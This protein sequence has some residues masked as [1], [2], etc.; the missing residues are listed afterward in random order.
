[1]KPIFLIGLLLSVITVLQANTQTGKG[2][3]TGRIVNQQNMP[4]P[5]ATVVLYQLPDTT[6]AQTH[7][8]S[9]TGTFVF[10]EIPIGKYVLKVTHVG[11]MDYEDKYL[12]LTNAHSSIALPVI[13]LQAGTQQSLKDVVVTATKPLIE[14]RIDRTIVNVDAMI[15]ASGYNALEALSKSPGVMV[16]LNDNISLNGKN[17]VLVLIDDRPTY[18][19]GADLAAYLRSLPAGMLDKFELISNPP[20]R[21]DAAGGV[22][23]NILLKKYHTNGLNGGLSAGY[24][25]G[26]YGKTN[27]ALNINY[28]TPQFNLFG[29][30][31]YG[32]DQD[33][34]AATFSR[35]FYNA[36]DALSSSTLQNSHYHSHSNGWNGRVG[37]DYF[38]SSKTTIGVMLTGSTRPKNDALGYQNHQYYPDMLPDSS[39]IG[40]TNGNYTAQN[41]GINLNM[42]HKFNSKGAQLTADLDALYLKSAGDQFSS[43]YVYLGDG[44]DAGTQQRRFLSPSVVHIYSAK[45]DFNQPLAGNAEVEAGV[46]SSFVSNNNQLNW[47]NVDNGDFIPDYQNSNHFRYNENIN[48]LYANIKKNWSRWG[49]QFGLRIENTNA[50][51]RQFSNPVIADSSFAKHY[52]NL[53]PAAYL[54]Y[55][56]D[57]SGH[58]TLT[59]SY[60][61]KMRRPG[62]QQ[63]NPFLFYLDQYSFTAGNTNLAPTYGHYAELRFAYKQYVSITAGYGWGNNQAQSLTQAFGNVFITRPYN[64]I[65]SET[66]S[67]V[68]FFS[69]EPTKWWTLHINAVLLYI[70]NKGHAGDVDINQKTNVHEIETSNEFKLG[71]GWSGELDGF[72]P[73]KQSFAQQANGSIYNISGGVRKKI[74]N[75]NGT[76]TFTINDV[77]HTLY[78]IQGQTIGIKQVAADMTKE[79]DTRRI[80]IAFSYRFGKQANARK[81]NHNTGGAEDEKGRAN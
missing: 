57:S 68:P 19:S 40:N 49:A 73:G 25:Q 11:Y 63:L 50:S 24:N 65:N 52:T 60:T 21:Y 42:L 76:L 20:A 39:G 38:A 81:R 53:F 47:F 35:Y 77:L 26:I 1:M 37:L 67:F 59:L 31:S 10:T 69:F 5:G 30:V 2:T 7:I 54:F 48:A 45:T 16:D 18:M 79:S 70:I 36:N 71:G 74:M 33:Y 61:G 17:N 3:L 27:N 6:A 8:A 34:N 72:F 64:F 80:G 23:I 43:L 22:I 28:H 12:A 41:I 62:Y 58:S 4:L 44:S 32:L 29:N 55:K 78:K 13:I 15:G 56:L 46:K 75:G 66:L 51:G 9:A 14:Q